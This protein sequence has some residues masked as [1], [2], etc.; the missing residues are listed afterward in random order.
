VDAALVDALRS[1]LE[2]ARFTVDGLTSLWGASADAALR[3]GDRVPARRALAAR[4]GP[5]ATLAAAFV[6]GLP[7][8]RSALALALPRLTPDGAIALGLLTGSDD[9]VLLPAV[10]LRPYTVLDAR[11]A[12]SWWVVSDLGEL[13]VGGALREDHVL[14][15]G[16]A[17]ATLSGLLMPG[18]V[19][20]ALDLGTGC[21][22]QALHLAREGATVV[23]T[24]IS[25]RA[26][27]LAALT[28]ALNGV[29][30][31]LR[32][33][34]LFAPVAGELFERIVSNPPFVITPRRDDV[35]AYEYRDGGEVGD[36]LVERVISAL[37]A[38][39]V[40]GGIAQLLGNWEYRAG[41]DGL[42]RARGWAEAAG[43][44]FWIVERETQ[45]PAAYAETWVRDGGTRPGTPE[46]ERLVE[47]WID[48]FETRGVTAVGF[49]YLLLRR[50][51]GAPTLGRAERIDT[52]LG[53]GAPALGGH[54]WATLAA[55]DRLAGLDDAGLAGLHLA[56]APDVTDERSHWPGDEH[57][58]V[59]VLR[60]GG[61]FRRE[62]RVGTALAAVVG[63]CDGELP[64][65]AILDA[66]AQLLEVDVAA[67]AAE[68][69]PELRELVVTGLLGVVET[70]G[71]AGGRGAPGR[72]A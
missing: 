50:P 59:M 44:D 55:H 62:F 31:D 52:P 60:Q 64:V 36:A 38:H 69:L 10:D 57:P 42:D 35:P 14:G 53:D 41:A 18:P 2:A 3:R 45:D 47:A 7:A 8:S 25:A 11:G 70:A 34:D 9:D 61:G 22:I 23:A 56:V 49:G 71:E 27:E 5:A 65:W 4:P 6:L 58:T 12:A 32:R 39:L 30:A 63:A 33:G 51:L 37:P 68:V 48:D 1:D 72:R 26:L 16:G 17:S 21:G 20:R 43:L 28:L 13:A 46:F 67:L 66:V 54:L 19:G 29:A 40:P 15:V 24:D